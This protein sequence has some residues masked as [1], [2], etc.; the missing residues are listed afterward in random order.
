MKE[1]KKL[2]LPVWIFIG[3]IAGILVGLICIFAKATSFTGTWLKPFGD[4]Y[5]NLLKFLVVPVVLAA[6][7]LSIIFAQ[8]RW[9]S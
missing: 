8:R 9:L 1:K 5:I 7:R 6:K 3:M 2:S 4:I